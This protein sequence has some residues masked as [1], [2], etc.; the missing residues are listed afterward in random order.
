M[1]KVKH[2]DS[3]NV[4]IIEVKDSTN[5]KE[6]IEFLQVVV[7]NKDDTIDDEML[8]LITDYDNVHIEEESSQ[9]IK[10][11]AKFV[12]NILA[13]KYNQIKWALTAN[14]RMP[15]AG[16]IYLKSLVKSENINIEV[17]STREATYTWMSLDKKE[18]AD[19]TEIINSNELEE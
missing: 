17:F 15:V 5:H 18:F 11:I 10:K 14:T 19:L 1:Y 8:Y 13:K 16:S 4:F 7:D 9:P 2:S 3:K 12:D 6:I